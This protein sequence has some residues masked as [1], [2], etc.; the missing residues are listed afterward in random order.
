MNF[1]D[2]KKLFESIFL[3]KEC[4]E[5]LGTDGGAYCSNDYCKGGKVLNEAG[6]ALIEF[7]NENLT[8]FAEKDHSHSLR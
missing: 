5:C 1:E 8:A 2:Y 6:E 4:P 3:N 7:L